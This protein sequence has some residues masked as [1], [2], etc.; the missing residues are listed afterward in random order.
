MDIREQLIFELISKQGKGL[1]IGPSYSP[2]APK[3]AGW[4]VEIV[5]HLDAQGLRE[6]YSA[7]N[8]D[9]SK[10][11]EVDYIISNKSLSETIGKRGEYDF[12]IASNVIEHTTDLVG[13]LQD[14]EKLL[15]S[16]GV[17]SLVVPDKRFC[18]DIFKSATTTGTILQAHLERR[19][20]HS[21]GQIFDQYAYHTVRKNNITWFDRE[22]DGAT[23]PHSVT[24]AYTRMQNYLTSGSFEDVHAWV[25]TPSS[26]RVLVQD[27]NELKLINMGIASFSETYGFEFF[28]TLKKSVPG[29]CVD[30]IHLLCQMDAELSH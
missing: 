11:E 4:N 23:L 21:P 5:D 24:D 13:F 26:F 29:Q 17:L 15:K 2:L 30:R 6:K 8:I 20:R 16:E 12:I 18:F 3:S 1:E 27:L 28:V 25:F 22:L 9:T 10:I 14:C 7:W 19:L